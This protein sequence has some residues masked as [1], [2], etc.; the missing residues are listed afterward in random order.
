MNADLPEQPNLVL[1]AEDFE[2]EEFEKYHKFSVADERLIA[3]LLAHGPVLLRGGRGSGKSALMMEAQRRLNSDPAHNALGIY[4]SLRHL[5]LIRSSGR[6]YEGFLCK[7]M[8]RRLLE[9]TDI[10]ANCSS[11]P[12]VTEVQKV[13]A[14]VS[15]KLSKRIVLLFDDAAH[16]GREASLAEFFDVFRTISSNSVSCKA[17]IY[18]GVTRFGV[19]FDVFSDATVI[20]LS[21][22]DEVLGHSEFFTEVMNLRSGQSL[23]DSLFSGTVTKKQVAGF[24]GSAVLG[25]MRSFIFACNALSEQQGHGPIGIPELTA[26]VLSLSN[27]YYWPLL[28]EVKPKLGPYLPLA[29]VAS[30][31]AA[32]LF[33]SAGRQ[34]RRSA[35]VLREI[36]E[37]MAKPF[38]ILEYAGFISKREASRAMKS[39]GR[40]ARYALNFCNLIEYLPNTRLSIGVF[41]SWTSSSVEPEQFH[42]G[43]KLQAITIPEQPGPDELGILSLPIE[44]L[45]KSNAYPYGLTQAKIELLQGANIHT[46][47]DLAD[48]SDDVLLHLESVGPVMLRRFRNVVGQAIWM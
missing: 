40:G 25:N 8:L 28:E 43:S 22:N 15:A 6:E 32:V 24:L 2:P 11:D 1:A 38:E 46:V 29:D 41:E 30:E 9:E 39:G 37:R 3:K 45:A 42:R 17:T 4:I 26:T 23:P 14:D 34:E 33:E 35:L 18:P 10:E 21:R 7:L 19:R 27:N 12:S 48:A 13:L 16:I 36:I 44:K 47:G 31:I 20:D 5:E